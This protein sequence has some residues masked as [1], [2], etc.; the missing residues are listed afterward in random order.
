MARLAPSSYISWQWAEVNTTLLS[1]GVRTV[2]V[3]Q[4]APPAE[5]RLA[6]IATVSSPSL[7]LG[8]RM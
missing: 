8:M 5:R 3:A 2:S 6:S 1:T 7:P 4:R